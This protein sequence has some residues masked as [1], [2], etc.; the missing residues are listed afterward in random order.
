MFITDLSIKRPVVSAVFSLILIVFGLFVFWKLPVRE[1]PSGL[2][3]PVVQVQVDYQSASA[4]IVDQEITQI[5]EDVIG[6][7]EGIKNIDSVSENGRSTIKIEF[8]TSIHLDAAANDV[9]EKVARIVDTLPEEA[10]APQILKQAAGFSTT[11]WLS[12]SSSTW[13]DLEL[14][15]YARRY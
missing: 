5:I 12:L 11:M 13:T 4:P 3:P 6:G 8:D 1:L 10:K 15:D 14:G 2:Q 7:V 9:R